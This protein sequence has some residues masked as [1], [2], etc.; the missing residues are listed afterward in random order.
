MTENAGRPRAP[1][2][3]VGVP[4]RL[5]QQA[6][7]IAEARGGDGDLIGRGVA[8]VIRKQLRAYVKRYRDLLPPDLRD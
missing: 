4:D 7:A 5:W 1:Q 2:R 8:A 3:G 6:A